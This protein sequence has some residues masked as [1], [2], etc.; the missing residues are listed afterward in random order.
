MGV[1][2]AAIA[3]VIAQLVSVLF[4]IALLIKEREAFELKLKFAD[5][6]KWESSHFSSF[7]KLGIPMALNNSAIQISAMIIN[8]MTNDYGVSVS[9]FAGISATVNTSITLILAAILSSSSMII[10]QNLAAGKLKRVNKTLLLTG[11]IT[12]SISILL[13]IAFVLFPKQL[14]GIF[15]TEES[16]LAI[17]P[18]Y[19]PILALNLVA[20]GIS[21]VTRSLINGSGNGKINLLTALLDAIIARI[22]FAV[23]FGVVLEWG[24]IGFWLGAALAAYVP[25]L[26][27]TGFYVSG[28]WKRG[29]VISERENENQA[30]TA[31]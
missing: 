26:I 31:E 11:C 15:T 6:V 20:S 21:P 3:T 7:L 14:F 5:L 4:S 9:A 30:V 22:G 28:L 2:G 27:G 13:I 12:V 18:S 19:L 1:G 25:I 8:S 10:G 29:V 17:V 23:L 16:V 24:Y